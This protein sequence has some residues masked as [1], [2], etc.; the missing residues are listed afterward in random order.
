MGI[1]LQE[2]RRRGRPKRRWLDKEKELWGEKV[3]DRATWRCISKYIDSPISKSD[4]E[5]GEKKE[6]EIS[7]NRSM[8]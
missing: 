5:E 1:E 8:E 2:R 3:Y 7:T 6:K 4:E